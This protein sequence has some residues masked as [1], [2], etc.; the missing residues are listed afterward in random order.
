VK[1]IIAEKENMATDIADYLC[2]KY[3][4][5]AHNKKDYIEIFNSYYITWAKGHL[6]KYL[7]P[8]EYNSKYQKWNID[9]LPIIPK[10]F[11]V[12]PLTI[13]K[14]V[15]RKNLETENP[16]VINQLNIIKTLIEKSDEIIH[17][18]DAGRE[19]QMIVDE[20]LNYLNNLKPVKR[21][22]LHGLSFEEIDKGF[23][24]L[25]DNKDKQKLFLT[26]KLRAE[27]DWIFGTNF[28]RA[29]TLKFSEEGLTNTFSVGRNQTP[30]LK[31]LFD[32]DEIIKNFKSEEYFDFCVFF[33]FEGQEFNLRLKQN[34]VDKKFLNSQGYINKH[35]FIMHLINEF[36]NKDILLKNKNILETTEKINSLYNLSI[37][38]EEANEK[39][40]YSI[41]K[42]LDLAQSLYEKK[43][44]SYPRTSSISLPESEWYSIG[45]KL[46]SFI[47][48]KLLE[49]FIPVKRKIFTNE[50]LTDH[51]A[52]IPL[53]INEEYFLLS[54]EEKQIYSMILNRFIENLQSEKKIKIVYLDYSIE[55]TN[56]ILST[57]M[58]LDDYLKI[59]DFNLK[60]KDNIITNKS[61]T[62][63]PPYF[64][65][66]TLLNAMRFIHK[67][68][69]NSELTQSEIKEFN[70]ILFSKSGIGTEST[71]TPL[72]EGL[73]NKGFIKKIPNTNY[74]NITEKGIELV[75]TLSDLGLNEIISPIFTSKF[76]NMF[77][78]MEIGKIT[79][80]EIKNEML[81]YIKKN[82]QIIKNKKINLVT[83]YYKKT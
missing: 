82:I 56:Y 14:K 52:I 2:K 83:D 26:S 20:I 47:A 63:P 8:Q 44:I 18:G 57:N 1:V 17:A 25:I 11:K 30:V 50:N 22:W 36:G 75:K 35:H 45:H 59:K 16:Y 76:E 24:N 62:T 79:G 64:T 43:L 49:N 46:N 9:D 53:E 32:R 72:I 28:S 40:S 71:R 13:K 19:G 48:N 66:G 65:E 41:Q 21:I 33:K 34:S 39:Y 23:K 5:K 77:N 78:N 55:K 81:S 60:V 15:G 6:L 10:T 51:H 42:T 31:L 80:L 29:I 12:K 3:N 73:K 61:M 69:N 70:K 7:E 74:I 54:N 4:I 27:I 38:Q 37:L 68:I 58:L 67:Y